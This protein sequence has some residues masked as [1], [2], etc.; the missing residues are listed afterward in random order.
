MEKCAVWI[1]KVAFHHNNQ[2]PCIPLAPGSPFKPRSPFP[3]CCPGGPE[4]NYLPKIIGNSSLL[5]ACVLGTPTIPWTPMPL[6][7]FG[8]GEPFSPGDPR[9]P[10]GPCGPGGP[11]RPTNHRW[12]HTSMRNYEISWVRHWKESHLQGA[13]MIQWT[14]VR[15][16]FNL[17]ICV[18][19]NFNLCIW[20]SCQVS[21]GVLWHSGKNCLWNNLQFLVIFIIFESLHACSP[22]Y[23]VFPY[24]FWTVTA[25]QWAFSN[26]GLLAIFRIN[27]VH[28]TLCQFS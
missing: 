19:K 28:Q 17:C 1:I 10:E 16:N 20:W 25:V 8:P 5:C 15:K 26:I 21:G 11:K 3:P 13:R 23:F 9:R 7:P 22:E 27:Q 24:I 14:F 18:R 4:N 12:G 6:S 2:A